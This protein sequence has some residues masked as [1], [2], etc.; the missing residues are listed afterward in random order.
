MLV[1]FALCRNNKIIIA[2]YWEDLEQFVEEL[3]Q[4]NQKWI[5]RREFKIISGNEVIKE[6]NRK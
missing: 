2:K 3:K 4:L 5:D 6:W 1:G